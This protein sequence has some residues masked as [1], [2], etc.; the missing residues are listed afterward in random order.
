MKTILHVGVLVAA[1]LTT[2]LAFGQAKPSA[3]ALTAREQAEFTTLL[4]QLASAFAKSDTAR[5]NQLLAAEYRHYHPGQGV[6]GKAT[7]L[8]MFAP[9]HNPYQR[10]DING[11]VDV[12]RHDDVAVTTSRVNTSGIDPETKKTWTGQLESTVTWVQRDGRWQAALQQSKA[13][14]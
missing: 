4:N 11:P 1:V 7:S 3:P 13:V 10:V 12:W 2:S 8:Q 9:G 5:L 6:D 14:R